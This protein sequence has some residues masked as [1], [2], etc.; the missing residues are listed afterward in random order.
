[1]REENE[2]SVDP[3]TLCIIMITDAL[4]YYT[5]A[6][7]KNNFY[8][9]VRVQ[10]KSQIQFSSHETITKTW[11]NINANGML[12]FKTPQTSVDPST[13]CKDVAQSADNATPRTRSY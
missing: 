4:I 7:N 13:N 11:F 9:V 5:Y 1:M 6:N 3:L 10:I 12:L 8:K 2:A